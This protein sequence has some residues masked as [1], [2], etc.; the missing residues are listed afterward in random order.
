MVQ[1]PDHEEQLQTSLG[2]TD[3]AG[4]RRRRTSAELSLAFVS[5]PTLA[6]SPAKSSSPSTSRNRIRRCAFVSGWCLHHQQIH[7]QSLSSYH[8]RS[9]A[10]DLL[11]VCRNKHLC[12]VGSADIHQRLR[13]CSGERRRFG[14]ASQHLTDF[15]IR[16]ANH[17]WR[18][19]VYERLVL[20]VTNQRRRCRC[21]NERSLMD[22]VVSSHRS[23]SVS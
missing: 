14:S 6:C 13:R 17:H 1:S 4:S 15:G 11:F 12:S 22:F 8:H 21:I 19:V 10:S 16:V 7:Q 23:P 9:S 20:C 3:F 5:K 18:V 2:S